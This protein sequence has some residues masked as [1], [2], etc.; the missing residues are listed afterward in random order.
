MRLC[1]SYP[2]PPCMSSHRSTS[3]A[4]S[5]RL[6]FS[7]S[8]LRAA[9]LSKVGAAHVLT[10]FGSSIDSRRNSAVQYF[11]GRLSM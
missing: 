1:L 4:A 7:C 5:S 8:S 3:S 6:S 2:N 10:A 11:H 9:L